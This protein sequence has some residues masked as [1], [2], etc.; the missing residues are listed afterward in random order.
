MS[1]SYR[2]LEQLII[3]ASEAIVDYRIYD[4]RD[5]PKD[6]QRYAKLHLKKR[7]AQSAILSYIIKDTHKIARMLSDPKECHD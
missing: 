7:A 6:S 5:G 3:A 1:V 4:G 2:E